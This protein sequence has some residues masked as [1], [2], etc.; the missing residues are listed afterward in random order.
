MAIAYD[1]FCNENHPHS[2]CGYEWE[3][4]VDSMDDR[5][6]PMKGKCPNCGKK[7]NICRKVSAICPV[8]PNLIHGNKR[9]KE[10][11]MH[12]RLSEINR[13]TPGGIKN[14]NFS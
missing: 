7:G 13:Q 14:W 8:D 9:L 6:L 10:S 12:E 1:Y 11:G 5:C 4:L 2:G 3:K